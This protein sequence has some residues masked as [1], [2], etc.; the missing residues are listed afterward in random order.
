MP[1]SLPLAPGRG[2]WTGIAALV[3]FAIAP[4]GS[5]ADGPELTGE[6]IYGRKCLSCHGK[7]G[8][9]SEDCDRALMGNKSLAGLKKLIEKTMPE[10]DPGTCVG[11]E[12]EKVASYLYD[13]FYSSEAQA[14]NKPPRVELSRLTVRQ[15]RNA[16]ADLV[17]SFREGGSAD[18]RRGLKAFYYKAANFRRNDMVAEKIDPRVQFDFG[19][20]G[21]EPEKY[22][23]VR[24]SIYWEGS[25]FAPETGD[26]EFIVRTDHATRLWVNEVNQKRPLIDAWVKSGDDSEFRQSIHLLGGRW[27]PLRLDFSKG[28]QG[29][30][31][32]KDKKKQPK[33]VKASISLEWKL[34]LRPAE[35][36]PDRNLSPARPMPTFVLETPFPPDDRSTGYE[37]GTTISKAWEQATTDAAIET[38]VYVSSHLKELANTRED[39]SDRAE[40]LREFARQ[41][42]KKAF[43]RPL[44]DEQKQFFIDNQFAEGRDP[45]TA[46]EAGDFTGAAIAPIPLSRSRPGEARRLRRGLAD[47]LR[48]V[49]FAARSKT[50]RSR[51][52]RPAFHA[53]A[54]DFARRTDDRRHASPLQAPRVLPALAEGG[55][56]ARHRQGFE[57]I[58]RI[59]R[60]DRVGLEDLARPLPGRHDLGRK[61]RFPPVVEGRL[62]VPERTPGRVLRRRPPARRP[63]RQIPVGRQR[64]LGPALASLPDGHICVYFD[65]IANPPGR[66]SIQIGARALAKAAARG[67]CPALRPTSTPA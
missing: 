21:P 64:A 50:P 18:D 15:Y 3:L 63:L 47:L 59:R 53:R 40:K 24:F 6:Q 27:Y 46:L 4:H 34:P 10:D 19:F 14:K 23:P 65:H 58:P 33:P 38:A 41:F 29:V 57:G 42:A 37:R 52:E 66:V 43:R 1:T 31:D 60:G 11:P 9:G 8:E 35:V 51:L 28:K 48:I 61:V 16:I 22:D 39:A 2:S 67:G 12:A 25:V 20:D 17:G 7:N 44:T 49:G 26:Y 54:G 30:D 62:R 5:F 45:L 55:A 32:S 13:R 36:I 56:S